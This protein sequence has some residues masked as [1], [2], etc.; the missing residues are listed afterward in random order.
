MT[1]APQTILLLG[2]TGRTGRLVLER[3]L[4]R[5]DHVRVVVR[6]SWRLPA[7]VVGHPG[8]SVVVADLLSLHDDALQR[9]VRG[10]DA[11]VSCLG[12][13]LSFE[14]VF[15]PPRDLVTRAT[16][17]VCRA[18]EALQPA[19]P[20]KLLLMSSV[21]VNRP[22]GLDT[23]RGKFER[24][25]VRVLCSLLPPAADNQQASDLL[26]R[27]VGPTHPF[28]QWV[29]IRPDTLRDGPASEYALHEGLVGSV[30]APDDTRRAN[31]ALAMCD[32]LASP[33]TWDDW[34]AK[35]PVILDAPPP[36]RGARQGPAEVGP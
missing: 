13:V 6:S 11:V 17:R 20:V 14:G 2:A 18:I 23:R 22:G 10:C 19:T 25:L 7:D 33:T 27:D 24:A 3:L 9:L 34:K 29:V 8:L 15:L 16:T 5:G 4:G 31:V 21:S 30:F 26:H 1:P 28:V 32:L 35:A 36:A 12:H